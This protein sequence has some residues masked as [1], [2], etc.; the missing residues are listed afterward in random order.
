MPVQLFALTI[1]ETGG[2][3]ESAY[4]TF[5]PVEGATTYRVRIRPVNGEY[6]QL[7]AS[8]VRNYGIYGRADALGLKLEISFVDPETGEK[9]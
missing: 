6:A 5:A 4:V 3:L 1:N 9:I 8:L 7:D 2:W